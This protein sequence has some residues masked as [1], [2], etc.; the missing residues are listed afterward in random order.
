MRKHFAEGLSPEAL[1]KYTTHL[2]K[3][4]KDNPNCDELRHL[5]MAVDYMPMLSGRAAQR[6]GCRQKN[7]GLIPKSETGWFQARQPNGQA[8]AGKCYWFCPA[9]GWPVPD[10][11][12]CTAHGAP[13]AVPYTH[14]TMST[15]QPG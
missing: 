4:A 14:T 10:H 13:Y 12:K 3:L 9:C 5:S 11:T 8:A 2:M 6:Y 15:T 7:C 1:E